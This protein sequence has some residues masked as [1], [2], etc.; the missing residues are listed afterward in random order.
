MFKL[1]AVRNATFFV[2][3]K[4]VSLLAVQGINAI[5]SGDESPHSKGHEPGVNAGPNTATWERP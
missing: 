5:K 1:H 3:R 4:N 2:S